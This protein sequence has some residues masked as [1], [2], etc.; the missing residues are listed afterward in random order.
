SVADAATVLSALAG[1]DPRDAATAES[2]GRVSERPYQSFAANAD[3][4]G[5]R[6]GVI[7]EFMQPFT[8]ADEDSVRI[9]EEALRELTKAGAVLVDPGPK[10]VLFSD[11]IATILPQLDTPTLAA[12][13]RELYPAGTSQLERTLELTGNAKLAAEVSLRLLADREPPT[14]GEVL[15]V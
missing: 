2:V 6:I 9:G 15:F 3:L 7:R 11:A 4:R 8:R 10:G 1:Y 13:Y 12:V 5:V 14:S